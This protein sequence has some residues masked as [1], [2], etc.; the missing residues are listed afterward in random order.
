[1]NWTLTEAKEMPK[2]FQ[3]M[4]RAIQ[5]YWEPLKYRRRHCR[6]CQH[7]LFWAWGSECDQ[8]CSIGGF[9]IKLTGLCREFERTFSKKEKLCLKGP[10]NLKS[11]VPC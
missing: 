1:M 4:N 6:H 2:V 10:E 7:G 8:Y 11:L 3:D 5:G 9:E